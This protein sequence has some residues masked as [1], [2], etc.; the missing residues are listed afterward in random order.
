MKTAKII[1]ASILVFTLVFALCGCGGNRPAPAESKPD[2][3]AATQ[4]PATEAPDYSGTY[5]LFGMKNES[6]GVG[7]VV[8]STEGLYEIVIDLK[9]DGTGTM[10]MKTNLNT[11]DNNEQSADITWKAEGENLTVIGATGEFSATVKNGVM[12]L[13]M[14]D[15]GFSGVAYLAKPDADTSSYEVKSVEEL[16]AQKA[17]E[18]LE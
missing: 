2:A 16:I 11:E 4:A 3:P 17:S 14:E 5:S 13:V 1:L 7:D 6:M 15:E 9:A 10:S 12:E 18:Y 8:V